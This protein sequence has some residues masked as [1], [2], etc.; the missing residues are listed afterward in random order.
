MI[1]SQKVSVTPRWSG[2]VPPRKDGRPLPTNQWAR[3]GRKRVWLVRWFDL[4]GGRPGKTF[5]SREEADALAL[6][7]SIEFKE[8]DR[9]AWARIQRRT[10]G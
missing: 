3:A 4:D 9:A 8:G 10:V 1:Q 7:K 2:P 6:T 5:R